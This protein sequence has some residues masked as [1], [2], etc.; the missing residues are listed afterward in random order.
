MS[1]ECAAEASLLAPAG[2]NS[3]IDK[4]FYGSDSGLGLILLFGH[5]CKTGI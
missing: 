2:N 4:A 5:D 3:V 1:Q